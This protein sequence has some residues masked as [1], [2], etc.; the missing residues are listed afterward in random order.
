MKFVCDPPVGGKFDENK[1]ELHFGSADPNKPGAVI[2]YYVHPALAHG[3]KQ[4]KKARVVLHIPRPAEKEDVA[5]DIA[6]DEHPDTTQNR[7][8]HG[9]TGPGLEEGQDALSMEGNGSWQNVSHD[10]CEPSASHNR[11]DDRSAS[12]RQVGMEFQQQGPPG[13]EGYSGQSMDDD[14]QWNNN[15]QSQGQEMSRQNQPPTADGSRCGPTASRQDE[16]NPHHGRDFDGTD[17]YNQG[18][19][20]GHATGDREQG[21]VQGQNQGDATRRQSQRRSRHNDQQ[22]H[23]G[24][25]Q[26]QLSRPPINDRQQWRDNKSVDV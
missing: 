5:I 11:G 12:P 14:R 7:P 24:H 23:P 1:H 16:V 8:P 25:A 10:D 3:D 2:N 26:Q 19:S 21:Y 17:H 13:H 4:M 22:P 20:Q 15:S 6:T 18:Q 9:S